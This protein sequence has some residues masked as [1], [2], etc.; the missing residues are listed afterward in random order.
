MAH[1]ADLLN[2]G[3]PGEPGAYD[4]IV[5]L[6]PADV[7]HELTVIIPSFSVDDV[8]KVP[9]MPRGDDLPAAGQRCLIVITQEGTAWCPA[10]WPNP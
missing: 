5:K 6:A 9:W 8:L 4:G 10:W 2:S 3:E 1:P 7:N